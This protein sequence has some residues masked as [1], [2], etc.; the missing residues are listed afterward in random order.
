MKKSN[1]N[2]TGKCKRKRTIGWPWHVCEDN[3]RTEFKET[4]QRGVDWTHLAEDRKKGED[5]VNTVINSE[6]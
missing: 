6:L 1:Q 3:I 2:F 5:V 4:A